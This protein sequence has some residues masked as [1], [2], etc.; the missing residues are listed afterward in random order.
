MKERK[1]ENKKRTRFCREKERMRERVRE[2][3]ID[4]ERSLME[5]R[6]RK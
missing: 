4:G 5:G 1:R 3:L 6:I 2:L